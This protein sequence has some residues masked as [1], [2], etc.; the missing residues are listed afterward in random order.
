MCRAGAQRGLRRRASNTLREPARFTAQLSR[1]P[2]HDDEGEVHDHVGV[3]H[4]VRHGLPVEH[5]PAPV[6]HLLPAPRRGVERPPRHPRHAPHLAGA[7]ERR[8]HRLADLPGGTGDRDGEARRPGGAGAHACGA[9]S[10]GGAWRHRSVVPHRVP[11]SAVRRR[12]IQERVFARREPHLQ[13]RVEP[14]S[15][16]D[17]AR[18]LPAMCGRAVCRK[19]SQIGH[20]LVAQVTIPAKR[21]RL[22]YSALSAAAGYAACAHGFPLSP[23]RLCTVV[24]QTPNSNRPGV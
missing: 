24:I 1:G 17:R 2:A 10:G 16:V 11:S 14:G 5:V 3:L 12:V 21:R 18:A 8:D 9:R 22:D 6:G 19:K 4:Q 23:Y 13:L 15:R 7:L 20:E